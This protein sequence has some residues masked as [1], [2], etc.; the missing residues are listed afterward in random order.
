M[1][2]AGWS[3]I[4]LFLVLIV[5]LAKPA[6]LWM[7]ALYGRETLPLGFVETGFYKLA[8]I[9]PRQEQSWFGYAVSLMVFNVGGITLLFAILKLQGVLPMNPQGFVGDG[10]VARVQHR[11]QLRHQYQLAELRR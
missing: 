8:G 6:G 3:M 4:L 1:T 11:G 2:L 5:A 9:D 10:D 7:H